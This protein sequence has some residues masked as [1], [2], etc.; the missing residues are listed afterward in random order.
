MCW[1]SSDPDVY[2]IVLRENS[3]AGATIDVAPD[4]RVISTGPYAVVRHPLY[5]GLLLFSIGIP[6]A[7][8]SYWALLLVLPIFALIV[9]RLTNE[10]KMLA[11]QLP[12]YSEYCAKVRWRL[13]PGLY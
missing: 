5:D 4:Q 6:L 1:L 2:F 8:G 7:L 12:G 11:K 9:A 13:L 3:F 10:E